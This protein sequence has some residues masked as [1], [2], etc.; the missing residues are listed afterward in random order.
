MAVHNSRS[1]IEILDKKVHAGWALTDKKKLSKRLNIIDLRKST[2]QQHHEFILKIKHVPFS[3]INT[4]I[5][6]STQVNMLGDYQL[7]MF[8]RLWAALYQREIKAIIVLEDRMKAP[9]RHQQSERRFLCLQLAQKKKHAG[10]AKLNKNKKTVRTVP[11]TAT[12]YT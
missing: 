1:S 4:V 6:G 11:I 12:P 3:F 10:S 5:N 9:L 2:H 7:E 8:W